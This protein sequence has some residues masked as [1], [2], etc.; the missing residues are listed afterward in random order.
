MAIC[1]A[2]FDERVSAHQLVEQLQAAATPVS[3]YKLI[4]PS[5][6][7][8]NQEESTSNDLRIKTRRGESILNACDIDSVPLLSP[9]LARKLRQKSMAMWLMPFGFMAGLVFAQMTGLQTFSQIGLGQLGEPLIGG[10][11]GM[12]SGW[13]G[14]YFSSRSVGSDNEDD[15]RSLNKRLDEGLWLHV[16]GAIGGIYALSQKTAHALRGIS[17]ANSITLNPQKILGITKTSSLLLVA[18]RSNLIE[19]FSTGLPYI[20]PACGD[21]THGGEIGLQGTRSAE[22]LKLWLGLRQLGENGIQHLLEESIKRRMYL[23]EHLDSSRLRVIS[24]PLHLISC[25]SKNADKSKSDEWSLNT[26][27]LLLENQFMLSRPFHNGCFY[28]KTVLG[29]PHTK[30]IHLNKLADLLNDSARI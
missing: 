25:T 8:S 2:V 6:I 11:L 20:E 26:R 10:L 1:V 19:T 29:N 14:S 12:G 30:S 13:L 3:G 22:V 23:E 24:G 7:A 4:R 5:K 16:D 15:L 9:K 27:K 21:D 18:N 17:Y 28:L